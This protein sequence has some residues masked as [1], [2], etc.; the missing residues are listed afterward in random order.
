MSDSTK[1]YSLYAQR[2]E[3]W[4]LYAEASTL[5]EV[6][7]EREKLPL[8]TEWAGLEMATGSVA[9]GVREPVKIERETQ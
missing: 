3:E 8:H 5:A 1:K 7:A 2:G 6:Y 4:I 9:E